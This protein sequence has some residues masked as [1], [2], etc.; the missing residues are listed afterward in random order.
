MPFRDPSRPS[1]VALRAR[2]AHAETAALLARWPVIEDE[3]GALLSGI[4]ERP[5]CLKAGEA[6]RCSP[7]IICETAPGIGAILGSSEARRG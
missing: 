7:E 6:P 2:A 3:P 1:T 5:V 4:S